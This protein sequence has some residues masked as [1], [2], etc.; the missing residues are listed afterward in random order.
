LNVGILAASVDSQ[1]EAAEVQAD[2][3]FPIAYG[4]TREQADM[5]GAWWN[6]RREIIQPS[7]FILDRQG[8]VMASTYSSTPVGRIEP[9][10]ALKRVK[11]LERKRLE[12][13]QSQAS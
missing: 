9:A 6:D 13:E 12:A 1:E 7:E 3:S 11:F 4:V 8:K 10:D 2:L 5:I